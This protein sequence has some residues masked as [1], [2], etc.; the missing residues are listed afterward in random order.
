MQWKF[1]LFAPGKRTHVHRQ[2]QHLALRSFHMIHFLR[3]QREKRPKDKPAVRT[4]LQ[5]HD[6]WLSPANKMS[7][8]SRLGLTASGGL[9]V[10]SYVEARS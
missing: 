1:I 6:I 4:D 2:R 10:P 3:G 5:H 8:K 7:T 9:T